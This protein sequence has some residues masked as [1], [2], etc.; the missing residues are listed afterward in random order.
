MS[1]SAPP[2]CEPRNWFFTLLVPAGVVFA[3]TAIA[4]AVIPSL[5][6]RAAQAGA[7][8]PPSLLRTALR[9]EGWWWLLVE[10]GVV[11]LL[12]LAAMVWDRVVIQSKKGST[13]SE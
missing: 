11:V 12:S 6:D 1:D 2:P 8:P 4:Y 7:A 3:I 9:E 5:E 13:L 10:T